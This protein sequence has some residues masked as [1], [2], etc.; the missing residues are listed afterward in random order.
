MVLLEYSLVFARMQCI[1]KFAHDFRLLLIHMIIDIK[2]YPNTLK[3]LLTS[4]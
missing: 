1:Q 4:Y 2:I 3:I